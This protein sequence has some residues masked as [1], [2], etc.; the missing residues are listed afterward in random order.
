M[1]TLTI[2]IPPDKNEGH[3]HPGAA[4]HIQSEKSVSVARMKKSTLEK[5]G[6]IYVTGAGFAPRP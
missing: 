4:P 3:M 1:A 5:S 6:K 2:I